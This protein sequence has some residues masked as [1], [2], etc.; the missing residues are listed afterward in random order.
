L[1]ARV[2]RAEHNRFIEMNPMIASKDC[3]LAAFDSVHPVASFEA[4]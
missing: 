4:V 1:T 3:E 2:R